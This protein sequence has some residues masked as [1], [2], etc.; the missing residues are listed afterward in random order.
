VDAVAVIDAPL[1]AVRADLSKKF[2]R[3]SK[4]LAG[5][6]FVAAFGAASAVAD[7]SSASLTI[8][9]FEVSPRGGDLRVALYDEASYPVDNADSVADAVV[10]ARPPETDVIL[11]GIRPGT[12]A[13]KLFQDFNG[14]GKFDQTWLGVPLEKFGFSND[15][16]PLLS[17][18]DFER[19]KFNLS[20]GANTIIIH[21]Q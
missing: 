18:P 2:G 8:K 12:Y 11:S 16:R 3:G 21:L 13:V 19:T 20:P 5:L 6:C 17:E 15:A 1:P 4:L 14:N 9:V 7:G 10:P